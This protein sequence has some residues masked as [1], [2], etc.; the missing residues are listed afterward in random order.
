[1]SVGLRTNLY[2]KQI[3]ASSRASKPTITEIAALRPTRPP[4]YNIAV[5]PWQLEPY[6]ITVWV[7]MQ[8]HTGKG[9]AQ[10]HSLFILNS[11]YI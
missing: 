4:S 2:S 6:R 9:T 3:A 5:K 1:M 10:S 8:H 11:S 7:K